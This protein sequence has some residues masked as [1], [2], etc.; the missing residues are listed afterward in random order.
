[1]TEAVK[2]RLV[3]FG[4]FEADLRTQELRKHGLRVKLPRQSFQVLEM[5][6]ER[7]G[8]LVTREELQSALWPADT[9]VD[10]ENGLN[11]AVKRIRA[12]LGDSADA[13]RFVETLPRLG[14]RFIAPAEIE[15]RGNGNGGAAL[16]EKRPAGSRNG[17][18]ATLRGQEEDGLLARDAGRGASEGRGKRTW[19][20]AL[21][22]FAMVV[23]VGL[24]LTFREVQRRQSPPTYTI[25][26]L[27]SYPGLEIGPAFSPDGNKVAFAWTKGGKRDDQFDLYV[28]VIGTETPVRLT[29]TPAAGLFPAWSPD[30]RYIAFARLT[31][32]SGEEEAGIY[33]MPAVGG[34]ERKLTDLLVAHYVFRGALT[35]APDGKSL[36]YAG[37][38]D[39]EPFNSHVFQL[40]L[41]TL[42][43]RRL[44]DP[45][46]NCQ[47]ITFP[48]ISPN[49][50]FLAEACQQ[51]FGLSA[52]YLTPLPGGAPRLLIQN[53]GDVG[54]LAW[55]RDGASLIYALRGELWRIKASGGTPE[56][57]WFGQDAQGP[58]IA[59]T[60]DRLA[61]M[62]ALFYSDLYA[63]HL[64]DGLRLRGE[65]AVR[66]AP[67]NV[68]QKNPE[69]SPDGKRVAFESLRTG[70]PEIW[71]SDAD[72]SNLLQL[73]N[74]KGPLTGTP[75]WSPDGR[76][77]VFDSRASGRP[78]LYVIGADGG[79][80]R[81]VATTPNGG[82]VPYWSHDGRWI[83]FQGGGPREMQLYKVRPEGGK[84][85]QLTKGSGYISR[86]DP[87]GKRLY[88][89]RVGVRTTIWSVS[90][91]G[92]DERRVEGIAEM[93]WPGF[94]VTR[95]GILYFD[96]VASNPELMFLDFESGQTRNVGRLPGNPAA[97]NAGV[98]LS[99]D[100]RTLL[101][102]QV[103]EESSDLM[104]VEG[105][106]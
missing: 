62:R 75:R 45:A 40:N 55:S 49:G 24:I 53:E 82:S 14:Y 102:P 15:P 41:E 92:G 73:T 13:P 10:F 16:A 35:W 66:F 89:T 60:G 1:M 99:P 83:Y 17:W 25:T 18:A 3:R 76:Q 22:G 19:H 104:L 27:T 59:P 85:V 9:F 63:V 43:K 96:T 94:Q 6:I 56:R 11:N 69:F 93:L 26:P 50:K 101:Y 81:V 67:A 58:S 28:K 4:V 80:P 84:A 90:V 65:E 48:T 86:E 39:E 74:F 30:G 23:F 87:E 33:M 2:T 51:T 38:A 95:K 103:S 54:G 100:G 88:Y 78:E 52:I 20:L 105:F 46:D 47:F 44:K 71:V 29:H 72:G 7:Q 36:L 12:V 70:N 64:G 42:E 32:E 5:L 106:K 77:I 8:D 37:T 61:Y 97:F 98:A 34:P 68:D 31:V 21:V 91:D 57:L 79:L